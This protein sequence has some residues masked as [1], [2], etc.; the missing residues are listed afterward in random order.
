MKNWTYSMYFSWFFGPWKVKKDTLYI[1]SD[2]SFWIIC[3]ITN[4][5]STITNRPPPKYQSTH[6]AAKYMSFKMFLS[7]KSNTMGIQLLLNKK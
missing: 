2:T 7:Y 6:F 4:N 1:S 5:D 3:E